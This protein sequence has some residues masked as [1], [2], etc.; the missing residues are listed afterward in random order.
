VSTPATVHS[1]EGLVARR[2]LRAR[3]PG[4]RGHLNGING[5]RRQRVESE[6][7]WP[8]VAAV[9]RLAYR[10]LAE[11]WRLEESLNGRVDPRTRRGPPPEP[12]PTDGLRVL[13]Q[14]IR[15]GR[16]PG[17]TEAVP[18][19]LSRDVGDLRRVMRH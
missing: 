8:V 5:F 13:A 14:A 4:E 2:G 9:E 10:V 15:Q 3:H 7:A 16:R 18:A 1:W 12:P 17:P 6:R 11:S 19:F